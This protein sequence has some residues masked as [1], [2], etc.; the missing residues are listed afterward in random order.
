MR[1][2]CRCI[3]ELMGKTPLLE[4]CNTEKKYALEATLLVKPE[5]MNPA[6]S[7]KDRVA[8]SMINDAEARGVLKLR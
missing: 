6:G 8:L 5:G 3:D 2:I 7:A 4:L 1:N